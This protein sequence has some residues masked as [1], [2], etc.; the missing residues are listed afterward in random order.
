[1]L[2]KKMNKKTIVSKTMSIAF[3]IFISKS[4]GLVREILQVNYFGVGPLADAFFASYKMPNSLRKIFAEGALSAA[5][6][7]TLVE[8]YKKYGVTE[9]NRLTSLVFFVS[10]AVLMTFC[11]GVFWYTQHV[12]CFL[13]PGWSLLEDASIVYSAVEFLRI[14]IFFVVFISASSVI[15][16]ALQAVHH[17]AIPA[18]SQTVMNILTVVELIAASYYGLSINI[19][20]WMILFNG[21]VYFLMHLVAFLRYDFRVALPTR[22]TW[23]LAHQVL[24]KFIPCMISLGAVELNLLIDQTFASYLPVGSIGLLKY[25]SDFMRIPLGVFAVS[26][27]TILLPYLSRI[28]VTHPRR[29]NY[30][31]LES[32]KCIAW[33]TLPAMLLMIFFS[34]DIFYTTLHFISPQQFTLEH[35]YL[36]QYL[37]KIFVTGLFFFSLNKIILSVYYALHKTLIPTII[38]VGCTALNTALNYFLIEWLGASGIAFATMIAM[39]VQVVGLLYVLNLVAGITFPVKSFFLFLGKYCLQII[40]V[41]ICFLIMY[42]LSVA[43][44]TYFLP[45]RLSYAFFKT[46]LLWVWVGPLC[47]IAMLILYLTRK[48]AGVRIHFLN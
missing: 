37:F 26:F 20:C 12:M 11:I 21:A 19:F 8:T 29:L 10:Q 22:A 25:S 48:M 1:M 15:A 4:L 28:S 40:W 38:V 46:I 45:A 33:V 17:F 7:P 24:T 41:G 27:A 32:A 47:L 6:V 34:H 14:L 39:A 16:G 13:A 9:A 23:K 36:A 42:Y 3:S 18:Y 43:A 2:H 31:L 30:Y 35:V 44:L 5:F